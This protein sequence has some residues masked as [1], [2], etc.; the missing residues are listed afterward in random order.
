MFLSIVGLLASTAIFIGIFLLCN[1]KRFKLEDPCY[2]VI[3]EKMVST[4]WWVRNK[5]VME[6]G[7]ITGILLAFTIGYTKPEI[8]ALIMFLFQ[9][10]FT[11]YLFI[12]IT[13]TKPRYKISTMILSLN[14]LAILGIL[15]ALTAYNQNPQLF[16]IFQK[17]HFALVITLCT[18]LILTLI[19]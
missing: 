6:V 19:I 8:S 13:Y 3:G 7:N 9:A 17:I 4:R 10:F 2:Y 16:P 14:F 15:Y 12:M 5:L 18:I 1:F 11:C